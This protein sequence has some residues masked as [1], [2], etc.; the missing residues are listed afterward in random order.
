MVT[1]LDTFPQH[2]GM[3]SPPNT[4]YPSAPKHREYQGQGEWRLAL[5]VRAYGSDKADL[6]SCFVVF[7]I[8]LGAIEGEVRATVEQMVVS[9]L[10][11][12]VK[13]QVRMSWCGYIQAA[14]ACHL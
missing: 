8:D 9:T 6:C 11:Y 13:P 12:T 4:E 10:T 1:L 14:P 7:S 5:L 2:R 3:E